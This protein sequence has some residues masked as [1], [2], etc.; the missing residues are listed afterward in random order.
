[1]CVVITLLVIEVVSVNN[2]GNGMVVVCR[3]Y[4][5]DGGGLIQFQ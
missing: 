3:Y 4:C 2:S 5:D 1:M